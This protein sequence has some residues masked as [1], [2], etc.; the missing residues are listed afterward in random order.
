VGILDRASVYVEKHLLTPIRENRRSFAKN[1]E[2]LMLM[3]INGDYDVE[4]FDV[5]KSE[6]KV[7]Y[8]AYSGIRDSIEKDKNRNLYREKKYKE[9]WIANCSW[10]KYDEMDYQSKIKKYYETAY[11]KYKEADREYIVKADEIMSKYTLP[12]V[13][14]A[15]GTL[16]N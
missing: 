10:D 8:S 14:N 12:T 2:L 4:T 3:L 16:E 13:A 11:L 5:C 1:E 9:E 15:I 6:I 7:I